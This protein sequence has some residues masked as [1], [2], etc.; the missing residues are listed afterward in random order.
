MTARA[1][2]QSTS[3]LLAVALFIGVPAL[4]LGLAALN[5]I[6]L[7]D[8]RFSAAEKEAQVAAL[9]R[10]LNSKTTQS[11][12][13]DLSTIYV[14]GASRSLASANLQ[15]YM[16]DTV[17]AT[18]ARLI[19]TA[20]MEPDATDEPDSVQDLGLKTTLET[21]NKGLLQLLYKLE[22]GIPLLN[23]ETLSVRRL[24]NDGGETKPGT[25]RVDVAVTGKWRQPNL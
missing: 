2:K 8:D 4:L 11:N 17:A 13:P 14:R 15:Q 20:A 23:V 5:V 19:E 22:S 24:P 7:G 3:R 6:Q 18:S 12:L 1:E 10:R 16:V 9:T 21:D 25:L